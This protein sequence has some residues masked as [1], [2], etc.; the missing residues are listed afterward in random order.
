LTGDGSLANPYRTWQRAIRDVPNF[1]PPGAYYR[2]NGTGVDETFPNDFV[3]PSWK[4]AVVTHGYDF[5]DPYFYAL[6]AVRLEADPQLASALTAAQ[7]TIEIADGTWNPADLK[8]GFLSLTDSSAPGWSVPSTVVAAPGSVARV[9]SVVTV[10]APNTLVV[11]EVVVLPNGEDN[12]PAA[13]FYA[14]RFVVTAA[15]AGSFSYVQDG[16]PGASVGPLTYE[17]QGLKGLFL[18]G[19]GGVFDSAVIYD[20]TADTIYIGQGPFPMTLPARIMEPSATLESN[21]DDPF[22]FGRAG[23]YAAHEDSLAL[24][25]LRIQP[26]AGSGAVS[27]EAVSGVLF[28]ELCELID[29]ALLEGEYAPEYVSCNVIGGR[30][31]SPWFGIGSRFSGGVFFGNCLDGG[32]FGN[33]F[34]GC[35]PVGTSAPG[36]FFGYGGLIQNGFGDGFAPIGVAELINY[37]IKDCGGNGIF[38]RGPVRVYTS[39]VNLDGNAGVGIKLEDGAQVLMT[40]TTGFN[41]I[42]TRVL[43]A[44]T[45]PFPLPCV[46]ETDQPHGLVTGDQVENFDIFPANAINGVTQTVT[47]IDATHF[48]L[49]GSD[50]SGEAPYAGGGAVWLPVKTV[51]T[52]PAQQVGNL[53]AGA[54]P[55]S[56]DQ[57]A[58]P[59]AAGLG[60]IGGTNSRLFNP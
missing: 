34:D 42:F 11:G 31:E 41:G 2:V 5:A 10:T 24:G 27:I 23:I 56:G 14:G 29:H 48:S 15:A 7:A 57:I 46:V 54:F 6:A 40:T 49:D 25:G 39:G 32:G 1:P 60:P 16:D 37:E 58:D 44:T 13:S 55:A 19:D 38:A 50:T 59:A 18:K 52:A 35:N 30:I 47:V 53:V 3:L 43:S 8:T 22:G 20:N 36:K 33:V 12:F 4:S 26:V 28:G 9:G 21:S 51:S 17:G 45:L